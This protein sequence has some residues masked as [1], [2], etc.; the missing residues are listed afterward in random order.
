MGL[1]FLFVGLALITLIG[2]NWDEI[3]RWL[4]MSGLIAL[5]A[6]TQVLAVWLWQ[7][8]MPSK[9]VA[10]FFLGNLFYGASIVLI[11]QVYHLGEH[12]PDGIFWWALGCLPLAVLTASRLLALQM[13]VLSMIW[14]W[15]ESSLGF[16]PAL[17]PVFLVATAYV[18]L[19]SEG[20]LLLFMGLFFGFGIWLES[21]LAAYWQSGSHMILEAEHLVVTVSLMAA[22][23]RLSY[24]LNFSSESIYRDYGA[25]LNIWV[26]RFVL[27]LLF[28]LSFDEPWEELIN[29]RWD[30]LPSMAVVSS[31]FWAI[32][33]FFGAKN[34]RFLPTLATFMLLSVS[35]WPNSLGQAGCS[36]S[37]VS[38]C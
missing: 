15:V 5:T 6:I 9:A 13:L 28:V 4:R 29:A 27:V 23:Y 14:W 17:L 25:V 31:I 8:S 30:H 18:L 35:N 1:G 33:L 37:L 7:K 38:N 11:A 16:Y 10:I 12:M 34:G 26:L 32:A 20:S 19:K 21:S 24:W 22:A 2:A 3:P 36:G